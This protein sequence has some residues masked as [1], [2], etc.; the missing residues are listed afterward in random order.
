MLSHMI[1]EIDER[2]LRAPRYRAEMYVRYYEIRSLAHPDKARRPPPA[3]QGAQCTM[4]PAASITYLCRRT[5]E[6]RRRD[7]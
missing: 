7:G 1:E 2:P 5:S 4:A 3:R 6:P